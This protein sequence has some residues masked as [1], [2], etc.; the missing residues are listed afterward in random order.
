MA[1]GHHRNT[2]PSYGGAKPKNNVHFTDIG[3]APSDRHIVDENRYVTIDMTDE[4][5][6]SHIPRHT[7]TPR[8]GHSY[9]DTPRDTAGGFSGGHDRHGGTQNTWL[10]PEGLVVTTTDMG[11]T[12]NTWLQPEGLAVTTTDMGAHRTHGYNQRV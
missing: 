11:C 1:E 3:L 9:D 7:S 6:D 5:H 8:H 2:V 12:Q 4:I 10:Q